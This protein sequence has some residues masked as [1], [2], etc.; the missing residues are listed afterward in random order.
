MSGGTITL[1]VQ[2]EPAQACALKRFA[3]KVSRS[4]A[5]GVL[6]PHVK[7]SI[8]E[9]Q[10]GEIL[11]ALRLIERGLIEEHVASWPWIETGRPE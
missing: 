2:L 11:Q 8:R 5:M 7:A 6:Y 10:A 1:L 3:E 4:E 9:D